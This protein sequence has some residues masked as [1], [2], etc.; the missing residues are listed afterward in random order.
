MCTLSRSTNTIK[1]DIA[2]FAGKTLVKFTVNP[3]KWVGMAYKRVGFTTCR[4][5]VWTYFDS[6][7]I[8]HPHL[9]LMVML[10]GYAVVDEEPPPYEFRPY[11]YDLDHHP[12]LIYNELPFGTYRVSLRYRID[13]QK[14]E[15]IRPQILERSS[16]PT[17]SDLHHTHAPESASARKTAAVLTKTIDWILRGSGMWNLLRTIGF[18]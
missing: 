15:E 2:I 9:L 13:S 3:Y 10:P 1:P 12:V 11:R 17:S 7:Q 14:Y 18:L 16:F 4:K 8:R 6:W 5:G